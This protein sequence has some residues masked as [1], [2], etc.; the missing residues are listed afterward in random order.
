MPKLG[1]L[2]IIPHIS[3]I[4]LVYYFQQ[5]GS[6]PIRQAL[7]RD[8]GH[9]GDSV[10][11]AGLERGQMLAL[12]MEGPQDKESEGLHGWRM[13]RSWWSSRNRD[14]SPKKLNSATNQNELASR[15]APCLFSALLIFPA[16]TPDYVTFKYKIHPVPHHSYLPLYSTSSSSRCS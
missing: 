8:W 5:F 3:F 1:A 11:W 14:F 15:F 12:E 2:L 10:K 7:T 13:T 16:D 9:P 6:D 4:K